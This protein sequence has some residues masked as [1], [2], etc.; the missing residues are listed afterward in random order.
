M[1]W[2]HLYSKWSL[3]FNEPFLEKPCRHTEVCIIVTY[4][5]PQLIKL[6]VEINHHG[7]NEV[8]QEGMLIKAQIESGT[9]KLL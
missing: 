2:S 5:V 1:G 4:I 8:L 6:A 3:P 7:R 9:R